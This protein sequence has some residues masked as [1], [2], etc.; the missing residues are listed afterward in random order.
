MII[1]MYRLVTQLA[2]S[3]FNCPVGN[4]LIGIHVALRSAASLPD[5]Q[6]KMV[7]QFAL[8]YFCCC[9]HDHFSNLRI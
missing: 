9:L 1:G 7:K 2:A 8:C 6:R 3:H 4:D 5:N